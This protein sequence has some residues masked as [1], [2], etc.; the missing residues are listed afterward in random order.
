MLTDNMPQWVLET[1]RINKVENALWASVGILDSYVKF[2]KESKLGLR[3]LEVEAQLQKFKKD[4][5]EL[6]L[7][8]AA[9]KKLT[10]EHD[11]TVQRFRDEQSA[12]LSLG[13]RKKVAQAQ[14][15]L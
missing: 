11:E 4:K 15:E 5:A 1:V 10:E 2:I 6:M 7:Q 9:V 8:Q 13:V 12:A 3:M 14:P